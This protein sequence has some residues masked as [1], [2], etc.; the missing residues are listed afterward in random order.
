[1]GPRSTLRLAGFLTLTL[2]FGLAACNLPTSGD[3]CD[4]ISDSGVIQVNYGADEEDG[5]CVGD[6]TLR[7]AVVLSNACPGQ[8][9]IQLGEARYAL[10]ILGVGEDLAASGDLDLRDDVAIVGGGTPFT[11]V[12]SSR[13]RAFD[14][15]AGVTATIRDV[16]IVDSHGSDG[17]AIRN[18]GT[19]TLQDV[20]IQESSAAGTGGGVLNLGDLTLQGV[21]LSENQSEGDGGGIYNA[22]RLTAHD[23][24]ITDS[25]SRGSGGGVFNAETASAELQGGRLANNHALTSGGAIH[26]QG[27]LASL[28]LE[29]VS[30]SRNY[31]ETGG[32]LA[33]EATAATI[34]GTTFD[35]NYAAHGA[36]LWIQG[37]VS[38][39]DSSFTGNGNEDPYSEAITLL[40]GDDSHLEMVDSTVEAS[41]GSG[42]TA[43]GG[44]FSLQDVTITGSSESGLGAFFSG[45][46]SS[47]SLTNCA[48]QEN[49][50]A[51]VVTTNY[52]LTI[53]GGVISGNH[54]GGIE[55]MGGSQDFSQLTVT[56]NA[57]PEDGG[58]LHLINI[59]SGILQD[60]TIS[61]NSSRGD[62]G[63]LSYWGIQ[64]SRLELRNVTISGNT[65]VERGG[66]LLATS[67]LNGR[68]SLRHV[69]ITDNDASTGGGLALSLE[70]EVQNSIIALN[71]GGNC[72][73]D[74]ALASLGHNL[75]DAHTCGF[76]ATGDLS[77]LDPRLGPLESNGGPTQTHA[78]QDGSPAIDVADLAACLDHDQRGVARPQGLGCDIGAYERELTL[79]GPPSVPVTIPPPGIPEIPLT[80]DMNAFCRS[81]PGTVYPATSTLLQG[82][83]FLAQGRN[84]DASW[85]NGQ[86]Q[87]G[88]APCWLSA[89]TFTPPADLTTLLLVAIPPTPVP[90]GDTEAPT[91]S[92]THAPPHPTPN[93]QVAFTAKA[94]DNEGVVKISIW[95]KKPGG[96][97]EKVKTCEGTD[98]CT[99]KGGPYTPGTG[100]YYAKAWD[101]AGND[102]KTKTFELEVQ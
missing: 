75:E 15:M 74:G 53:H 62:G 78:L 20:D 16:A 79:I 26:S 52:D 4:E 46:T 97:W 84:G 70:S 61:G 98:T 83:A 17:G 37:P 93:N 8:Q 1:M 89:T 31:A 3:P 80:L 73:L 41:A 27:P 77:G 56:G 91:V 13:D 30:L 58:G 101:A 25:L 92:I 51:G 22:G 44:T 11:F 43:Q 76:A 81:G 95:V 72:D 5:T 88:G 87:D 34:R 42:I 45:G 38:V 59:Q 24:S 29:D 36:A 48:I 2:S 54:S 7:E 35:T 6:C 67:E 12:E 10:S 64:D 39:E 9:T 33:L 23:S 21:L 66:G 86:P 60:M 19:L 40:P 49:E 102:A 14:V 85:V 100:G 90:T 32:A 82:A 69:T 94:D 18:A 65:A 57:A 71:S 96:D 47:G 50:L 99:Y 63:G 68:L 28:I 55:M